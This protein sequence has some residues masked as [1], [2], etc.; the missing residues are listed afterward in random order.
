MKPEVREYV[1]QYRLA[2]AFANE[3]VAEL[4]KEK[5]HGIIQRAWDKVQRQIIRDRAESLGSNS[6]E[7]LGGYYDKL[8]AQ[9]D[10]IEVLEVT[11]KRIALKLTRCRAAEAFEHL[12]ATEL[13]RLYCDT[14]FASIKAFNPKMKLMRTKTIAAGDDHCDHIFVLEE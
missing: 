11:D 10:N 8:A 5:A 4:G 2:V 6:L 3:F 1:D 12:G 14:D 7:A 9:R 13:C